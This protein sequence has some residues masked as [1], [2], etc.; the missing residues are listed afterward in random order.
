MTCIFISKR[1]TKCQADIIR[2]KKSR[3][4]WVKFSKLEDKERTI[5]SHREESETGL[6]FPICK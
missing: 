2:E 4:I 6:D 1:L 5:H 3:D